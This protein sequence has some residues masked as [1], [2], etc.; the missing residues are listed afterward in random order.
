MGDPAP[1]TTLPTPRTPNLRQ[2]KT[3]DKA[4]R[5]S[6][7]LSELQARR[8]TTADLAR[9]FD[10]GQRSIQRDIDALRRMGHDV[11]EHAGQAYSIPKHGTLLRPAEALAAYAAIRL[12]HHHSPP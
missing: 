9:R 2:A 5:L 8:C 12:A 1:T 4:K 6:A 3:W 11:V 7:L 10:V